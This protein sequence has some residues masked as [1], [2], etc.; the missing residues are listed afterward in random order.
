LEGGLR[1]RWRPSARAPGIIVFFRNPLLLR[2]ATPYSGGRTPTQIGRV[3]GSLPRTLEAASFGGAM[4]KSC[5]GRLIAVLAFGFALAAPPDAYALPANGLLIQAKHRAWTIN[6]G[7][8]E[9]VAALA[10]TPDGFL[11]LGTSNGLY[12]FDGMK[13][14]LVST[15]D[16][17]SAVTALEATSAGEL[18][19]GLQNGHILVMQNGHQIDRSPDPQTKQINSIVEGRDGAVWILNGYQGH[20]IARFVHDHWENV[21]AAQGLPQ[22]FIIGLFQVSDGSIDVLLDNGLYGLHPG[23]S[24]FERIR[25]SDPKLEGLMGMEHW[26][27]DPKNNFAPG[28]IV[29]SLPGRPKIFMGRGLKFLFDGPDQFW[30]TSFD[31]GIVKIHL[32]IVPGE[33]PS[34]R[35]A[36]KDG[37]S[38]NSAISLLEDREGNVWIGTSTGLDRFSTANV[39]LE[40]GVPGISQDGFIVGADRQGVVYM[41]DS[42]TLYRAL[43]GEHPAA[44]LRGFDNSMA[45]CED[46][47][48]NIW[49]GAYKEIYRIPPGQS[50]VRAPDIPGVRAFLKCESD[51][52]GSPWFLSIAGGLFHFEDKVWLPR[53]IAL[54]PGERPTK[55]L[56]DSSGRLLVFIENKGLMRI[57][58]PVQ[59]LWPLRE[60]PGGRLDVIYAGAHEILLA[61]VSGLARLRNDHVEPLPGGY[62]WLRHVT[63]VVEDAIGNTWLQ[64]GL[65]IYRIPTQELTNAFND[66]RAELHPAVFDVRDGLPGPN[67]LEYAMNGAARGADGRVWFTT[68]NGIVWI[69]PAHILKNSF[70]PPVVL[71]RAVVDKQIYSHPQTLALEKGAVSLEIDFAVLSLET[72]ERNQVRYKLDGIDKDWVNPGARREAFYT[73][74]PPGQYTFRVI[75]S[76]NDGV[77]N[78]VG[79]ALTLSQ[80]PMFYQTLWFRAVCI[81]IGIVAL[82]VA[83]RLRLSNITSRMQASLNSRLAERE[84]IARDLHDTLLQGV[85]G[86][87]L[88]F[89]SIAD[90]M[91]DHDLAPVMEQA[92]ERAEDMMIESRELLL[93][94]RTP[95]VRG[96][97]IEMLSAKAGEV[98]F[99]GAPLIQVSEIGRPTP[100]DQAAVEELVAIAVE[101]ISNALRHAQA[102][103]IEVSVTYHRWKLIVT[104]RDDGKG[105]DPQVL[106]TGR[107]E[108]H[109]GLLGMR[110]RAKRIHARLDVQSD[111]GRG[112]LIRVVVPAYAAYP[113]G[114]F[115]RVWPRPAVSTGGAI[116]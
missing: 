8:P 33:A 71:T 10:Q 112:T 95:V 116:P 65:G 107:R 108:A 104:V 39:I 59:M 48:A 54:A 99:G 98:G 49:F 13:F 66:S 114:W 12:R 34:E 90:R 67:L 76:N 80:A 102:K 69:D 86:L 52:L 91:P 100:I 73:R 74:L 62:P 9:H 29:A 47:R 75:G 44:I 97:L 25:I 64:S 28:A 103:H 113:G 60:I 93:D 43:P 105:I 72:P 56:F 87:L 57:D 58:D 94:L 20:P 24:S 63:G 27:D 2:L 38:A 21:G 61:G 32:P 4:L 26:L 35:F 50:P 79:A 89:Q 111:A 88:R 41:A 17:E 31:G 30:A 6:D 42:N 92:L 37:L 45:I 83:Y 101:A 23:A 81:F 110:E 51:L 11:W 96:S 5:R 1:M 16:A 18:W 85:H 53:P 68:Q 115:S 106:K 55:F 15:I 78:K 82:C 36:L 109:F 22:G 19:V 3:T 77:W 70:A 7:A 84:R 46:G 14:E 40:P